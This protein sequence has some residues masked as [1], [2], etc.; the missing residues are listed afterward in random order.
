MHAPTEKLYGEVALSENTFV[1]DTIPMA[2]GITQIYLP[3]R[4]A[5]TNFLLHPSR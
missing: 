5:C 4:Q 2:I 3:D 1:F